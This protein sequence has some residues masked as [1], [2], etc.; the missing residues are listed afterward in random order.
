MIGLMT[1]Q[2]NTRAR[3]TPAA[4][5]AGRRDRL[6]AV[7]M[8]VGSGLSN[9]VGAATGALAFPV[10]GP[11]GVV[12]VRQWVAGIVLLAVG[13]PR[14]RSFSWPQW[15]PVLLLALVFAAMNLSLYTAIDRVGL[16]LAVTLEFLGPLAVALAA[17][18]R[19]VD[20]LCALVAGAAVVVLARPQVSTDYFGI[21]AGLLAA[22]CWAAYILLGRTV[23]SRVPGVQGSAAAAGISAV[24]Y[25]PVGI[26]VLVQHPPTAAALGCAAAAG[27]LS[28]A[29]PFLV[30]VLALR[31]VSARFF[32]VFMSVNPVL[33]AILGMM[34]LGHTLPAVDWLAIA[35]IVIANAVSIAT[36]GRH[37]D[38]GQPGAGRR[39]V[40]GCEPIHAAGRLGRA[41][42]PRRGVAG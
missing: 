4:E 37:R 42:D 7:A 30:D 12:A 9:Q 1:I 36:A 6:A 10:L 35:A 38:R 41:S 2:L 19:L 24:L 39:G 40:G 32:G 13:R 18:R 20:L 3:P 16:G 17:S 27:I 23:G 11:V 26:I 33:A 25:V 15:W 22:T 28:S 34:I 5:P 8:M 29:V 21:A 14:L 31:R